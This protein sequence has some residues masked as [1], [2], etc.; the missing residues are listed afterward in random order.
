MS[1][2]HLVS[3]PLEM[4]ALH[5][6]AALR[7]LAADEGK[8]LHHLLGE[9]YGKG[10]LQPF[11]LMVAPNATGATLYAYTKSDRDSLVQIARDCGLPDALAVCDPARLAIK[12]MP[13]TWSEGRRLA[14][15][16]RARPVRRLI[17]PAGDFPKGAEV[18]AFLVESLRRASEDAPSDDG[19]EREATYAEWLAARLGGAARLDQV[20]MVRF[21]RRT[22]LRGHKSVEG[23]DVTFHGELTILDGGKFSD[24]L[25]SGVGRHCAY[26]Y[27]MMLL[28][29]AR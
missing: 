29:P 9:S 17:K 21:E 20:R 13:E 22:V 12:T 3:L 7:S 27:G 6:W 15:D 23:P 10:A 14:F 4:R 25:A 18:D 24:H 28:R 16:L 1:P 19:P 11:R 5:R 2:L 8:A 26:G